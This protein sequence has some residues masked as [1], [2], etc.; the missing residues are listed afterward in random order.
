LAQELGLRLL[1]PTVMDG[2]KVASKA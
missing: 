2:L 1:H